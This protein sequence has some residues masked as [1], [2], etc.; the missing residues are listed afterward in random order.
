MFSCLNAGPRDRHNLIEERIYTLIQYQSKLFSN[1][2]RSKEWSISKCMYYRDRSLPS[3]VY[4]SLYKLTK[5]FINRCFQMFPVVQFPHTLYLQG[6][7]VIG[8]WYSPWLWKGCEG[9]SLHRIARRW[10]RFLALA[11]YR[12]CRRYRPRSQWPLPPPRSRQAWRWCRRPSLS[13][14]LLCSPR[15]PPLLRCRWWARC[16]GLQNRSNG[17]NLVTWLLATLPWETWL[18]YT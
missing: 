9:Y 1:S 8:S 18:W 6:D 5:R 17:K 15:S 16:Q 4:S 7:A 13:L 11:R 12:R 3:L 10:R 14:H 2:Q